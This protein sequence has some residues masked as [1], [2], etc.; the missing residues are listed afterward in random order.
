MMIMLRT[1][2]SGTKDK[3]TTQNVRNLHQNNWTRKKGTKS[4]AEILAKWK[5]YNE[6]LYKD[7]GKLKRKAWQK[8]Q[9]KGV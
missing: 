1:S 4:V 6:K 5:E 8:V 7:D 9:R 3:E 2:T